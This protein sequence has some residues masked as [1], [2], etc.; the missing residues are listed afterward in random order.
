MRCLSTG[1]I[2]SQWSLRVHYLSMIIATSEQSSR[3]R[4]LSEDLVTSS[5]MYCPFMGLVASG[6]NSRVCHLS[7]ILV[8]SEQSVEDVALSTSFDSLIVMVGDGIAYVL[9]Y[10]ACRTPW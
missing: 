6:Q 5:R 3:A 7:V 9:Y 2:A 1:L 4:C 10:T 8:A